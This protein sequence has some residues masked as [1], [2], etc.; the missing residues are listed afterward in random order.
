MEE[1]SR[2]VSHKKNKFADFFLELVGAWEIV[3]VNKLNQ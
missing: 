1:S 3:R 2:K